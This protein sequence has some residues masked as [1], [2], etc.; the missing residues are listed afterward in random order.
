MGGTGGHV[1]EVPVPLDPYAV[2]AREHGRAPV[3][4]LLPPGGGLGISRVS[5]VD[6]PGLQNFGAFPVYSASS[7]DTTR[8]T[9]ATRRR[10]DNTVSADNNAGVAVVFC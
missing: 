3:P 6:R 1:P 7:Q 9:H 5:E 2:G 8:T 10:H 4:R